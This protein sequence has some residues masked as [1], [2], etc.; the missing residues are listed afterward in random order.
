MLANKEP[1]SGAD[2]T[3][4]LFTDG[5]V[6]CSAE[7]MLEGLGTL[8]YSMSQHLTILSRPQENTY[9]WLG[10]TASPVTCAIRARI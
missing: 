5:D 8:L 9:G 2:V 3:R 1:A 7:S 6:S 4:G 10:D